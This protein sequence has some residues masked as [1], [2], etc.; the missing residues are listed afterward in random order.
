MD[1]TLTPKSSKSLVIVIIALVAALIIGVIILA[2]LGKNKSQDPNAEDAPTTTQADKESYTITFKNWD[3][4]VLQ[5]ITVPEGETPEYTGATPTRPADDLYE[6]KFSGWSK[7]ISEAYS[8]ITYTAKFDQI[9]LIP[10]WDGSVA[11]SFDGGSGTE[12]DPYRI[13]NG[14]QLAY[15]AK[16][17]NYNLDGINTADTYYVL[18]NDINLGSIEWT[19]IGTHKDLSGNSDSTYNFHGNFDGAQ[20][21][22]I[23]LKISERQRSYYDYF[24]LFGASDGLIRALDIKGANIAIAATY[25]GGI[26]GYS[27]GEMEYCSTA[28]DVFGGLYCGGVVGFSENLTACSSSANVYGRAN[29]GG[30]AGYAQG[31]ITLC[32]STGTVSASPEILNDISGAESIDVGGL[33]GE[34]GSGEIMSCH[35]LASVSVKSAVSR[36]MYCGGLVGNNHADLVRSYAEGDCSLSFLGDS[37]SGEFSAV[38]GLL[39]LS[40]GDLIQNCYAQGDINST[41]RSFVYAGGFVGKASGRIE[42]SYASGNISGTYGIFGGGFAGYSGADST[43]LELD[44][45]L[46]FG[47]INVDR[48]SYNNECGGFFGR[49][50]DS[51]LGIA[52]VTFTNCYRPENQTV[53]N[54]TGKVNTKAT[55]LLAE[56]MSSSDFYTSTLNWDASWNT[57]DVDIENKVYPTLNS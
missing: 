10:A 43:P 52:N 2:S 39:G 5:T 47:N 12:S 9:D 13:A 40:V 29:A 56:N 36:P 19:P 42:S 30:V 54:T 50:G 6:Y 21:K 16:V 45:C 35:S 4:S 15:L 51:V 48:Q 53:D 28:G 22:I 49:Y 1:T 32:S 26:C 7:S 27:I 57:S 3:G 31:I 20:R 11:D 17:V 37:Y 14:A 55:A 18:T 46:A 24:G 44:S 38:G 23:N 34:M 41:V 33:I 25:V 8:D